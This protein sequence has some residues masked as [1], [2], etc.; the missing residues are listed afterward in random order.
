MNLFYYKNK[1]FFRRKIFLF[2]F[3][4]SFYSFNINKKDFDD[5]TK[6]EKKCKNSNLFIYLKKKFHFNGK[7]IK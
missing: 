7:K 3:F 1:Y 2:P 6:S 5:F 4:I